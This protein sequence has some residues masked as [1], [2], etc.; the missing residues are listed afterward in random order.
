MGRKALLAGLIGILAVGLGG[1][2][3]SRSDIWLA[4]ALAGLNG[5]IGLSPVWTGNAWKTFERE[6]PYGQ[7]SILI[8]AALLVG[9]HFVIGL[10]LA[11]TGAVIGIVIAVTHLGFIMLIGVQ[12]RR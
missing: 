5:A 4:V 1:F 3:Q 6:F 9:L 7:T 10:S 12:P 11:F 8:M 2:V